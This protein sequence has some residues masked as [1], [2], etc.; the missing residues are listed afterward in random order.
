MV[1]GLFLKKKN[2]MALVKGVM[3]T[4]FRTREIVMGTTAMG[5][6]RGGERQGSTLNLVRSS[7]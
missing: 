2:S 5:F 4:L 3:Q 6:H 1:G 7:G